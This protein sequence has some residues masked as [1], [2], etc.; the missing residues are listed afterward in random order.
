V[1]E[2]RLTIGLQFKTVAMLVLLL[3][4]VTGLSGWLYY[5]V[6]RDRLVSGDRMDAQ[7]MCQSLALAGQKD[8]AAGRKGDLRRICDDFVVREG[9]L[10]AAMMD[11][12]HDGAASSRREVSP[13]WAPLG[14]VPMD[15]RHV[16]SIG[17]D[18]LLV[19]SPIHANVGT[20]RDVLVGSAR[21]VFDT[22]RTSE[23]LAEVGGQIA[24]LAAVIVLAAVTLSLVTVWLLI[25][26]PVRRLVTVTRRIGQGDFSARSGITRRDEI[27]QLSDAI[28]QMADDMARSRTELIEANEDLERKVAARTR[29]LKNA[30]HRLTEEMT[31]KQDFLRAVSHDLNAP[32]RNIAGTVSMTRRKWSDKLPED[33]NR[34][35]DRIGANV[36]TQTALI[37][38]LLELSRI[39][40]GPQIRQDVDMNG[41]F[42]QLAVG[43]EYELEDRNITLNVAGGLPVLRIEPNR[44]RQ[45]FQNL[46]DNA[47]KYMHRTSG[48]KIEIGYAL[49][50]GMHVFTVSDNGPG[51]PPG[52][53]R[54]VFY[55]F[56]RGKDSRVAAIP[57]RG[58]GLAIVRSVASNHGGAASVSSN[59]AGGCTF[60]VSLGVESTGPEGEGGD[61][62]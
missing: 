23:S 53:H 36:E 2:R 55:V 48:G 56:R 35:F 49:G 7:R 12:S 59:P 60:S 16:E 33:V 42:E 14:K 27:G 37:D 10:Y 3:V 28:E 38:D 57:G 21:I 54:D 61:L 40:S 43:F 22:S 30:N 11:L 19:A 32:L 4:I 46:I 20:K 18:L 34:R 62:S 52:H 13:R 8:I 31:E 9:V 24:W 29:E 15:A 6:V 25:L 47:I 58:V 41:M 45:A 39:R 17:D 1:K 44:V 50:D 5:R 51:I 26:R